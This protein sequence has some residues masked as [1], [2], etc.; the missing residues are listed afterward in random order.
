MNTTS[1]I[2]DREVQLRITFTQHKT[3]YIHNHIRSYFLKVK[4]YH[5][6][7][8]DPIAYMTIQHPILQFQSPRELKINAYQHFPLSV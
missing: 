4:R 8:E 2:E 5:P 6:T 7:L 3:E 1:V